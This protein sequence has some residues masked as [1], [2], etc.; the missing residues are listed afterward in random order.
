LHDAKRPAQAS[1]FISD[2][3]SWPFTG[4]SRVQFHQSREGRR[5]GAPRED[6]DLTQ[7]S[8]LHFAT[9]AVVGDRV[10]W[11]TQ[12][13]LI[14]SPEGTGRGDDGILKMSKTFNVRLNAGLFV[15]SACETALERI[16]RL[17]MPPVLVHSTSCRPSR[18]HS[19]RSLALASA[20]RVKSSVQRHLHPSPFALG[21]P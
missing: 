20:N 4:S 21:A 7:E 10:K 6:L 9:H 16:A 14:L 5:Q 17:P 8:I 15:L 2:T 13:A 3:E 19:A 12:P 18:Q 11:V 1:A